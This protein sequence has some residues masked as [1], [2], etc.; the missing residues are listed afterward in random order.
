MW[1]KLVGDPFRFCCFVVIGLLVETEGHD[2]EVIVEKKSKVLPSQQGV[3]CL[4]GGG[5]QSA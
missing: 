3:F 5:D 4:S 1:C 2:D